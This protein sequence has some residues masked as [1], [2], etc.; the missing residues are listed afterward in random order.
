MTALLTIVVAA[1]SA[2]APDRPSAGVDLKFEKYTLAN[3]LEVILRRD[4]AIPTA[5]VNLWYHVGPANEAPGRT[6]FAHLFE[7][8]MFR[9]SGHTPR[10][11]WDAL[12][13]PVGG[14]DINATTAYDRTNY[15][16]TVP[17]NALERALW[18]E[19]D[20]M[21]F[22]LDKLDQERLTNE[23]S[24][25]RNERRQNRETPPY[26]LSDEAMTQLLF[27]AGHPYHA[28]I[29]GSHAD[30]QAATLTDVRDFFTKYYVPN[31]ASLAIV[32]DIDVT[33]TKAMIE[34][35]FGSIPR[36]ADVPKPQVEVPRHTQEQRLT[37]TDQV[38]LPAV[39]MGWVTPPA[40][41]PG[42]AEAGVA[43]AALGGGRTSRLYDALVQRT[44]IAQHVSA[45]QESRAYGSRF[46]ISAVAAPGHT[47]EELE[48][49]IQRELDA[50]AAD[51]P[52]DVELNAVRTGLEAGQV[53]ALEDP[54]GVADRLNHYNQYVGDPGYLAKDRQRYV[55][56]DRG[57]VQRFVAEQL[58]KDKRVVVQTV[59]GEKVLPPDPPAP[60]AGPAP[61]TEPVVSAEPWRNAV[62]EPGPAAAPVLPA[63]QRFVLDNGLPVYLVEDHDL[64][65][66]SA[67]L[68]TRWGSSAEPADKAGLAA[69]AAD[70]LTKGTTTRD[71]LSIARQEEALGASL[72]SSADSERSAV[73]VA[74][75]T[76]RIGEAMALMADVVRAPAFP[77]E[78][79]DRLREQQLVALDQQRDDADAVAATVVDRELYGPQHPDGRTSADQRKALPSFTQEDLRRYHERAFSPGNSALIL[80]GDLT[81][82]KARTLATEHFGTWSGAGGQ[83][84]VA[85]PPV[86]APERVFVVDKPGAGQSTVILAQPGTTRSDPSLP[87]LET[88][89]EVLG[90]G[91]GR[92]YRNLRERHGY[93]Y[94]AD[95]SIGAGRGVALTRLGASVQTEATGPAIRE[96]LDEVAA[97][98]DAPV[99]VEELTKAKELTLRALPAQFAS[100]DGRTGVL[101]DLFVYDL[102]PDHFQ[103]L[104]AA[105]AAIDADAVQAAARAHLRP[106][107]M[108]V[109]V[110]GDRARIDAQ[111]AGLGLGPVTHL[112]ADGLPLA[113]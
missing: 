1:C 17:P 70:M 11:S 71:E 15:F 62:P 66:A 83:P 92:L 55:D 8:M 94:G 63:A 104:P 98:R 14:T 36:G 47:V 41:A 87:T 97:I 103:K 46:T 74:A 111:L 110:V 31:N 102:P 96:M 89:N 52:T 49:A 59:P 54:A 106:D 67:R 24:A 3:G 4:P 57:A 76:P 22:L 69:F 77:Q 18:M 90:G 53:F 39:T 113:G 68:V 109:V 19:S 100:R 86:P 38:E 80:A 99:T 78:E 101:A 91:S 79:I 12:L 95:S 85:G 20:R 26:A 43:A 2:P 84:P 29:I 107:E 25:V 40:Y 61:V 9:G 33:A 60:A 13:E 35:Y 108:K 21:G 23:Q 28:S 64:P 27:P 50:L 105:I 7:H 51:G 75:L 112:D 34:K 82:E 10:D 73:G 6:G 45:G 58:T 44:R 81:E 37:V 72:T 88:M 56:V 32:G 42:D 16:E 30:I 48:A 65:L 93:A 5:A